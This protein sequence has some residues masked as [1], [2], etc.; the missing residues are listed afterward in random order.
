MKK[1]KNHIIRQ[2][3]REN[4]IG[5]A[6]FH[7]RFGKR[8]GAKEGLLNISKDDE[9]DGGNLTFIFIFDSNDIATDTRIHERMSRLDFNP[10]TEKGLLTALLKSAEFE[11]NE[12]FAIHEFNFYFEKIPTNLPKL[13]EE[14]FIPFFLERLYMRI[15]EVEWMPDDN[16]ENFS[17]N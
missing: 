13:I 3:C 6:P 16:P 1:N 8:S 15:G 12:N 17:A 7:F 4:I 11:Q 5:F 10:L 9:C 14:S 2:K